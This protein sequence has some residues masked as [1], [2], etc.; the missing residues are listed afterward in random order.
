MP[1][2][3][4]P[5]VNGELRVD[6]LIN[7]DA[8]TLVSASVSGQP[9]PSPIPWRGLIDTGSDIT[10]DSASLLHQLAVPVTGQATTQAIGG[11]VAVQLYRI[12]LH[13]L[14]RLSIRGPWI[15]LWD[16]RLGFRLT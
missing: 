6:V 10:A 15:T 3:T 4:F 16:Y 14:D 7:V 11:G 9:A 13:L 1:R 8:A 12:S 2:L 5:I